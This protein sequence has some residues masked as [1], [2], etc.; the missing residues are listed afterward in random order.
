M[1]S[2]DH[3]TLQLGNWYIQFVNPKCGFTRAGSWHG[4]VGSSSSI[5]AG[6]SV[7]DTTSVDIRD[8]GAGADT[9][10]TP[11]GDPLD[12]TTGLDS[13]RAQLGANA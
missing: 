12:S 4:T 8:V 13:P 6:H 10:S 9:P 2:S 7:Y 3:G 1:R 5:D 11:W